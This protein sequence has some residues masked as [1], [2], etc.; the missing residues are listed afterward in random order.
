V[1]WINGVTG[2]MITRCNATCDGY[3]TSD[4]TTD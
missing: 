3:D 2:G 1:G 4:C